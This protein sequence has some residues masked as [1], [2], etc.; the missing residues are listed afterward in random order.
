ML[1]ASSAATIGNHRL[2]G[3]G[4]HLPDALV[5]ASDV[6]LIVGGIDDIRVGRKRC[7]VARLASAHVVPIWAIDGAVVAAADNGYGAAVLLRTI[8]AIGHRIVGG[9]MVELRRGLVVLAR[10]VFATIQRDR[11]SAVV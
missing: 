5:E 2:L 1:Q 9:D 6:P 4:S 10:P 7:D 11:N 8:N 3:D